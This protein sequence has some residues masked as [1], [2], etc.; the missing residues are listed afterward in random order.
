MKTREQIEN[1]IQ[2]L[3]NDYKRINVEYSDYSINS[4]ISITL[5]IIETE[6]AMLKW[7]LKN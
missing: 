6:I 2:E 1:K 7:V 5:D 4:D 3:E